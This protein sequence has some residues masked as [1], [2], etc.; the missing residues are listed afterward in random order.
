MVPNLQSRIVT[1]EAYQAR[2]NFLFPQTVPRPMQQNV[3][4]QLDAVRIINPIVSLQKEIL[5]SSSNT[6]NRLWKSPVLLL[7][8]FLLNTNGLYLRLLGLRHFPITTDHLNIQLTIYTVDQCND[9]V[10]SYLEMYA[11]KTRKEQCQ[12]LNK[13]L[14]IIRTLLI[15]GRNVYAYIIHY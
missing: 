6:L 9:N 5:P 3:K 15:H 14:F 12:V 8:W 11:K 13:L 10:S 7:A 2:A 1:R 4:Q